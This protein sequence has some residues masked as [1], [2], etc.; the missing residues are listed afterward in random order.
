M[1]LSRSHGGGG[2]NFPLSLETW[3]MSAIISAS[4][5]FILMEGG[6][7]NAIGITIIVL[8]F[9]LAALGIRTGHG[10]Y[11]SVPPLAYLGNITTPEKIDPF[12]SLFFGEDPKLSIGYLTLPIENKL[13]RTDIVKSYGIN[14]AKNR[15]RFGLAVTGLIVLLG[16]FI[17]AV[18][19]GNI[20]LTLLAMLCGA[21]KFVGYDIG[22]A[23]FK[24]QETEFGEVFRGLLLG[25][26]CLTSFLVYLY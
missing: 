24:G 21:C 1:L 12:I 14:K 2:I 23:K 18:Y 16:P 6:S 10:Q 13:E 5:Y 25:L 22:W 15:N 17:A 26:F 7:L 20:F 9:L 8:S 4:S 3:I 11:M 19:M